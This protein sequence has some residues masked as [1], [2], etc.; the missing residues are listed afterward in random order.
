MRRRPRQSG[1]QITGV[2]AGATRHRAE[3]LLGDDSD[4][5]HRSASRANPLSLVAVVRTGL[6]S[7]QRR[8][9]RAREQ[10]ARR[11]TARWPPPAP[12]SAS[13]AC[14]P[15][16]PTA[17]STT[18][19]SRVR[20]RADTSR[21]PVRGSG[22]DQHDH[23]AS[24]SSRAPDGAVVGGRFRRAHGGGTRLEPGQQH[25]VGVVRRRVVGV[26]ADREVAGYSGPRS[27]PADEVAV[28]AGT[29]GWLRTRPVGH[30]LRRRRRPRDVSA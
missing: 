7:V 6:S 13:R 20:R 19:T 24:P 28:R 1:Q 21:P 22:T 3:A 16:R 27:V 9:D 4:D 8:R 12:A 2:A 18:E 30:D 14:R 25:V 10:A 26:P 5:G 11:S 17:S 29:L 23:S 15:R